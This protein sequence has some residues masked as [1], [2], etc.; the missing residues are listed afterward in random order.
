[1]KFLRIESSK[2]TPGIILDP[3]H[4]IL[5]FYGF[6]LPENAIEFYQPVIEWLRVLKNELLQENPDHRKDIN[7]IFKLVYYN[8]SSLRQLVE[9][10]QIFSEIHHM[11]VPIQIAW[12]YDSEDP[13]MADSGRELGD[14]THVPV[15][16]VSY[17]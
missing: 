10:F 17:N 5:E 6:S 2:F 15:N 9:I 14:I 13:Q 7:A 16:I 8:S 12:Q 4:N 3:T 1:M 11:G